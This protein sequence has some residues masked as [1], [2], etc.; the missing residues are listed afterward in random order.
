MF[1][2]KYG[3]FVVGLVISASAFAGVVGDNA[4]NDN[5]VRQVNFTSLTET[6]RGLVRARAEAKI[7]AELVAR[8]D[9]LPFRIGDRFAKGDALVVFDCRRYNAE[10]KAVLAE[11]KS[12]DR[13]LKA[14]LELKRHKAI[15]GNEVEISRAKLEEVTAR[16]EALK[17]RVGQCTINA[18]YNG[19]IVEVFSHEHEMPTAN[20]PLV[21]IVDDSV[22]EID[23]I[24]PSRWLVWIKPGATFDFAIDETQ[25]KYPARV[26]SIA[27]VV[28]PISQTVALKA[29]FEVPVPKVLPGMSGSAVFPGPDGS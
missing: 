22:L 20:S 17:V 19:R 2:V 13:T 5:A 18:P 9:K 29:N 4:G 14:N 27:A 28:D 6:P 3:A 8:I 23:L 15:G 11:M 24:V 21:K 12:A 25:S 1:R 26:S 10:L 7:A 16:S